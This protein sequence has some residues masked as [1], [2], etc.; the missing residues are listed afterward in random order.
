MAKHLCMRV[1]GDGAGGII[2]E[3]AS[4][5]FHDALR[6]LKLAASQLSKRAEVMTGRSQRIKMALHHRHDETLGSAGV[7]HSSCCS[8]FFFC[9]LMVCT[10]W[11][12]FFF[13]KT[14]L[15]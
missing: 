8:L 4:L 7:I 13:Y 3:C 9:W 10:A 5:A 2:Q 6:R 11:T 1:L 12:L 14:P 15:H